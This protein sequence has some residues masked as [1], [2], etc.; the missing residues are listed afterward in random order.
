MSETGSDASSVTASGVAVSVGSGVLVCKAVAVG[1]CTVVSVGS[2]VLVGKAVAVGA[3]ILVAAGSN[4]VTEIGSDSATT[5][6][7][8]TN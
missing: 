3:G 4:T 2:G 5:A 1:S 8:S 6:S 7:F